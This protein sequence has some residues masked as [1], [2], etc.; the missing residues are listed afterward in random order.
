MQPY[1]NIYLYVKYISSI[2]WINVTI[3]NDSENNLICIIFLFNFLRVI[4]TTRLIHWVRYLDEV[5][6]RRLHLFPRSVQQLNTD[7]I[8][9]LKRSVMCEEHR[10]TFLAV[11]GCYKVRRLNKGVS[12]DQYVNE[13]N[14]CHNCSLLFSN[15]AMLLNNELTRYSLHNELVLY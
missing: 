2:I 10:E 5:M 3:F 11:I 14:P 6:W 9:F 13:I 1:I 12:I 8:K 4:I 15:F 7:T